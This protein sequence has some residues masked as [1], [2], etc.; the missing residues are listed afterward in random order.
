MHLRQGGASP[1]TPRTA[2]SPAALARRNRL[3]TILLMLYVVVLSL[4]GFDL[5]M[6][7]DPTWYSGLLGGYYVVTSLYPGFGLVTFLAIRANARGVTQVSPSG[8]PGHGQAHLRHV[9]HVDVLLLLPVPRDLVRQR[10]D[11]DALLPE[12]L[13][14]SAVGTDRVGH[15]HR[16]LAHSRS[17]TC[18]SG[19]PGGRPMR[20]KVFMVILFL[21]W[22]AIFVERILLVFPSIDKN[23]AAPRAPR[24]PDHRRLLLALR[25]EPAAVPRQVPVRSASAPLAPAIRARRPPAP[26]GRREVQ[27]GRDPRRGSA[28]AH[29]V[30]RGRAR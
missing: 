3:A 15:L 18:S 6:S 27:Y 20:H 30:P 19:S 12:P 24:D 17:P 26:R 10:A 23:M 28:G 14:Q 13:L 7:L 25:A 29:P 21:G 9:R 8:D 4:W 5:L 16:G 22:I 2:D 11:R 1:R